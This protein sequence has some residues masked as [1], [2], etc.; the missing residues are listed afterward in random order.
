MKRLNRVGEK[1]TTNEGYV[2]EI[3]EYINSKT[4]T[5]V[6][7]DAFKTIVSGVRYGDIKGLRNP[8]HTTH[9]NKGFLG[10]GCYNQK[11]HIKTY[12]RWRGMLERCYCETYH[13]NKPSYKECSI[14]EE[15]YNFQNFAQWFNE[16]YIEGFEL[17]KDIL[18]KGNK[19]YSPETCCFVPQEINVIFTSN[20]KK[21]GGYP[22]GVS[23]H[24]EGKFQAS[25]SINNKQKYLGLFNT[26]EEAF[27][28]YKIAKENY[29]KEVADKW[30]DLIDP[31]VYEAMYDYKVEITD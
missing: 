1:I 19:I 30:K 3:L 7:D 24:R 28:A 20:D 26:P 13:K 8:N 18:V 14:V 27:Q 6:F 25:V 31:R 2:I 10:Q 23:L 12:I 16:N 4:I 29:I 15:W 21:R 9:F 5:V 17:D 22:V 11:E